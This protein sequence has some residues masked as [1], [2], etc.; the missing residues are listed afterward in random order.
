MAKHKAD[1][2][3][4]RDGAVF[5]GPLLKFAT[6]LEYF[7]TNIPG[8]SPKDD[9]KIKNILAT[10]ARKFEDASYLP[11][12]LSSINALTCYK[13]LGNYLR[14]YTIRPLIETLPIDIYA[15]KLGEYLDVPAAS[16][17]ENVAKAKDLIHKIESELLNLAIKDT[18]TEECRARVQTLYA[19]MTA[20]E[21]SPMIQIELSEELYNR[22]TVTFPE[23][24]PDRDFLAHRVK[25]EII[26]KC[27]KHIDHP[28]VHKDLIKKF[29][30][31]MQSIKSQDLRIFNKLAEHMLINLQK[32]DKSYALKLMS[33]IYKV[34]LEPTMQ[35]AADEMISRLYRAQRGYIIGEISFDN[36]NKLVKR[37][38]SHKDK[39][40]SEYILRQHLIN[41]EHLPAMSLAKQCRSIKF[42]NLVLA[43]LIVGTSC[44][45]T[46]MQATKTLVQN[47]TFLSR[48]MSFDSYCAYY[49]SFRDEISR[50]GACFPYLEKA[51]KSVCPISS[52][53]FDIYHSTRSII[54]STDEHIDETS[55]ADAY[56]GCLESAM[57]FKLAAKSA[58]DLRPLSLLQQDIE[59][60]VRRLDPEGLQYKRLTELVLSL[61][62]LRSET[63]IVL[64]EKETS[65]HKIKDM[66]KE[67]NR[68]ISVMI[69]DDRANEA[70]KEHLVTRLHEEVSRLGRSRIINN[71]ADANTIGDILDNIEGFLRRAK[72]D[73]A[74]TSRA[75][76]AERSVAQSPSDTETLSSLPTIASSSPS[77]LA[78]SPISFASSPLSAGAPAPS[79]DFGAHSPETITRSLGEAP[80][81]TLPPLR[82]A[83]GEATSHSFTASIRPAHPEAMT[84]ASGDTTSH[85]Y[86]A[87]IRRAHP[88]AMTPASTYYTGPGGSSSHFADCFHHMREGSHAPGR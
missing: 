54:L 23:G 46:A 60:I 68:T 5:E 12:P 80:L 22:L 55:F 45:G 9:I 14:R 11:N 29:F 33:T 71:R 76:I 79:P 10:E 88:D 53:G 75:E 72:P 19:R 28:E 34:R 42:N 51:L 16:Y 30:D 74:E 56:Y 31:I 70:I 4:L 24:L 69:E 20:L 83:S 50:S 65:P 82:R 15:T 40:F 39:N 59:D 41:T 84:P 44:L 87:S 3:S 77:S 58:S 36:I 52:V 47:L 73:R 1:V 25:I 48:T 63:L 17:L 37:I 81:L 66:L 61:D 32:N 21:L 38:S 18:S 7:I 26:N 85:S 86:A 78:S 35:V 6:A 49:L 67:L 13:T 27:F 62:S 64:L 8:A 57:A 2:T 43:Q